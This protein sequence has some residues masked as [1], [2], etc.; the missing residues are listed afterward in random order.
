MAVVYAHIRLDTDEI[1]YIGRGVSQARS[2]SKYSRN[3]YW[4]N[5]VNKCGY[6]TEI[7][8][9]STPGLSKEEAWRQAGIKEVA[10]IKQYGRK[11]LGE[12]NLVNMT[13]GGEGVI[14][15]IYT[16]EYR[17]KLR[18]SHIGIHSGEKHPLYGK[19]HSRETR[20]K[21]SELQ[22]GKKLSKQHK[23]NISKGNI[24]RVVSE[25]TRIK[26]GMGHRGK[27]VSDEARQKMRNAKL[28]KSSNRLGVVLSE[29]NKLKLREVHIGS[30]WMND[31][32][33]QSQVMKYNIERYLAN[34]W[35]FGRLR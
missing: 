23:D 18:D 26:I 3:K 2:T 33:K 6:R 17:Q 10:L 29:A 12:G 14:G 24:G 27:R 13:N 8:W 9:K 25:E 21:I 32:E 11:D 28:G 19:G 15:K 16:D 34:G 20:Q 1:F 30:R 31:G 35:V 4:H 22:K 7:L 5:I